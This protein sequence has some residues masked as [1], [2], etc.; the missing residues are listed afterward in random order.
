MSSWTVIWALIALLQVVACTESQ[1]ISAL[2]T[3]VPK[4][5]VFDDPWTKQ[6]IAL[7]YAHKSKD[8]VGAQAMRMMEIYALATSL[9]I[10]YLHRPIQCVG[11]IGYMVHYRN[12]ACNLTNAKDVQQL[13]KI[14]QMVYLPST[15]TEE[16]VSDWEHMPVSE[17]GWSKF[18]ALVEQAVKQQRSTLFIIEFATSVAHQFPDVFMSVAAFRPDDPKTR[19]QC[20]RPQGALDHRQGK[21]WLLDAVRVAIHF[22][23]GDIATNSRWVHRLLPAGYYINLAKQITEVLEEAGCVYSI[24]I[25][26]EEPATLA[27]RAELRLLKRDIPNAVL[28]VGTDMVWSWQMM[29]TADALIMSNSAFSISAALLNPNGFNVFF[30]EAQVHQSRIEMRHWHTPKDRNGTLS[31]PSIDVLRRRVGLEPKLPAIWQANAAAVWQQ[32]Q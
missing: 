12:T 14:Q 10:G 6:N 8:G 3:K 7:V 29:A 21:P 32:R 20:S 4:A 28:Q 16:A 11:H 27:G 25:Y 26:T 15:V 18:R 24:E 22:R 5:P 30:P 9:G 23:R 1:N 13:R 19:L 2:W 31:A 17:F